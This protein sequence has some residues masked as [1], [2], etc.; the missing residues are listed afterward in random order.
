MS[1]IEV[2]PILLLCYS[3]RDFI[4][5]AISGT[6]SHLRD[7]VDVLSET[8]LR[9]KLSEKEVDV[10]ARAIGFELATLEMA[11]PTEPI[12]N[13]LLHACAFHGSNTL[14]FPRYCPSDSIDRISRRDLMQFMASYYR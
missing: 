7:L 3:F 11:P 10:A 13:D 6:S 12:L 14:G 1:D 4:A 9:P 8:V 2:R 5:Y